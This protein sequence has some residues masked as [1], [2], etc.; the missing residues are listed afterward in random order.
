[1]NE[2]ENITSRAIVPDQLL[3]YVKAVSGMTS[4]PCGKCVLHRYENVAVLVAYDPTE[5]IGC[6]GMDDAVE[7][8]LN[9]PGLDQLTV[10]GPAS[11]KLAPRKHVRQNDQY[12]G[13]KLENLEKSAKLRNTL[14]RAGRDLTVESARG[15]DAWGAEH[16]KLIADFCARKKAGLSEESIYLFGQLKKYLAEAP[17]AMLFSVRDGKG[18]LSGCAIGD[19]SS[20]SMAF[21]MFAFRY[22]DATPGTSDLLLDAIIGEAQNRGYDTINLGLGINGGVEFFKRKWGAVPLFPYVECSWKIKRKGFLAR[23]LGR[24]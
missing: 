15:A 5:P 7:K 12:W 19:Y 9:F 8:A 20:F 14:K 1:M 18:A 22:R 23:I 17:D 3:P 11:P 10:L 6:E 13:I 2:L 4:A 21:Y 24:K 16:E